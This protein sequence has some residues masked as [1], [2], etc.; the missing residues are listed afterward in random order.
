MVPELVVT[1]R[2]DGA[3]DTTPEPSVVGQDAA[4]LSAESE[5]PPD[6]HGDAA[7]EALDV[8]LSEDD[9]L[10]EN[11]F[12]DRVQILSRHAAKAARMTGSVLARMGLG[13]ASTMGRL[14]NE[15]SDRIG[16][17]RK[18]RVRVQQR[19]VTAAPPG[20]ALSSQGQRLRP[21]SGAR[22]A[23]AT[24]AAGSIK[25]KATVAGAAVLCLALAGGAYSI[26][27]ASES[28]SDTDEPVAAQ[29]GPEPAMVAPP[30]VKMAKAAPEKASPPKTDKGIVADV[31]LFGPTP[32]A[33]LEPAPLEP[34]PD[35]I[36]RAEESSAS[37]ETFDDGEAAKSK[38]PKDVKPWGNGRL[39]LPFVHRLKLDGP[40]A[41][42]QGH[43]RPTGFSVFI[44]GSKV[45]GSGRTI[46]R[47]DD[48]IAEVRTEN[49]SGGARVTFVFRGNIPAYKVRLKG[50]DVEFFISS[51]AKK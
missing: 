39:V 42:L 20:G 23:V 17:A 43:K 35:D 45:V 37:D 15:A 10:D 16:Q 31:P 18:Q 12:A 8:E 40:G 46:A 5:L 9:E 29:P 11:P 3:E 44:P 22:P 19:R 24:P 47:R 36:E 26:M 25:K 30:A 49:E 51:P 6:V 48:R 21:Q 28:K 27:G 4:E 41:G 13:A 34:P 50:D 33:T 1:L 38:N 2:Y 7:D 32:M 14:A